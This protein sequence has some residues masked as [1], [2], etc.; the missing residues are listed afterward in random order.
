MNQDFFNKLASNP[1][2][3]RAV[4]DPRLSPFLQ[5]MQ[6][7]PKRAT[8]RMKVPCSTCFGCWQP[9][10]LL[11]VRDREQEEPELELIF[12]EFCELMGN[13]LTTLEEPV[14]DAK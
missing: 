12:K 5:E 9:K 4:S 13:H 8:A 2:L 7:D 10:P 6:D 11:G 3:L 1:R 14:P